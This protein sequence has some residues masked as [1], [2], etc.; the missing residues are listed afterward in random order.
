MSQREHHRPRRIHA[1]ATASAQS[2]QRF[3][4]DAKIYDARV[5]VPEAALIQV[6]QTIIQCCQTVSNQPPCLLEIASGTGELAQCLSPH[7]H[8]HGLEGSQAMFSQ[9][10]Q[11]FDTFNRAPDQ[12]FK[13]ELADANQ[14]WP[15][16][17][18]SQ[19]AIVIARAAH[20]L[21][22][23]HLIKEVHRC[24]REHSAFLILGRVQKAPDSVAAQ[25]RRMLHQ[26]LHEHG[27]QPRRGGKIHQQL[28]A[29]IDKNYRTLS[30]AC[31]QVSESPLQVLNT[32][33]DKTGLGGV[34]LNARE[35]V[36]ILDQLEQQCKE[37]FGDI[38][39]KQH[40]GREYQLLCAA[41]N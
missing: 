6:S 15:V 41:I 25:L 30:A 11:R 37:H 4:P 33:R 9:L 18:A 36:K 8:Y 21:E 3:D 29:S 24:S 12:A 10:Q 27:H 17:D 35:H 7:C 13:A 34:V 26:L 32:W 14:T 31:W 40:S 22:R 23:D 39:K 28:A 2:S 19:D 20:L 5:G 16:A 1:D 38:E